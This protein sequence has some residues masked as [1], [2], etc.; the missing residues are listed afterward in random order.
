MNETAN[1][2][3]DHL[4]PFIQRGLP[5]RRQAERQTGVIDQHVDVSPVLGQAGD[6]TGDRLRIAHV[7]SGDVQSIAKF[8]AKRFKPFRTAAGGDDAMSVADEATRES[9]AEAGGRAGDKN[10]FH[11][12]DVSPC[13]PLTI[14]G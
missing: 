7:E 11:L 4:I 13:D 9:V 10:R 6:K 14:T 1:I 12:T 3:V 8:C 2:G 5:R